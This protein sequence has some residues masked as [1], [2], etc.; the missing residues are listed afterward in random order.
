MKLLLGIFVALFVEISRAQS[1]AA[2]A[3]PTSTPSPT[4][5]TPAKTGVTPKFNI[6]YKPPKTSM[7]GTRI[8]GTGGSRGGG[9]KVPSLYVL[10]PN[11]TGMTTSAQPSLFWYQTGPA[12]MRLELTL[13]QPGKP[14]P[15]LRAG[16]D[17]AG[18]AGIH[19]F[20]LS[21]HNVSLEPGIL[22]KW[23]VALVPDPANRSQEV[24][25]MGT[26]QRS[27]P[28]AELT[29]AL[30]NAQGMERAALCAG[31]GFWY[32]A[33]EA[34]TNQIDAA[35]NDQ[36]VRLQRARLLD[37]AGLKEAAASDRK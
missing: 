36:A 27:E 19:R 25:A 3:G 15:L 12:N 5:V 16:I 9:V 4:P 18:A 14:K 10:A 37:E 28:N 32:D 2:P 7:S 35:P 23:S 1:P 26:I 31:K 13:V 6:T 11:H 34:V 17:K 21:K 30:A 22:Y 8:D 24:I 33:L 29:S 20:P